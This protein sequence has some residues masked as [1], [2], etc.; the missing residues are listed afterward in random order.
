MT[1]Q[2]VDNYRPRSLA[3]QGDNVLGSVRPSVRPA[4]DI[5]GLALLSAA[6][7]NNHHYQSKVIVCVSVISDRNIC[8]IHVDAHIALRY[9][10]TKNHARKSIGSGRRGGDTRKE[11]KLGNI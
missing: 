10:H 8:N 6:M 1:L 4:V 11:G 2:L 3:K 7:S 5:R 9:P